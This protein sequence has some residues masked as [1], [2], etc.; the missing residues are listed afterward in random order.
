MIPRTS[1]PYHCKSTEESLQYRCVLY[2]N[3]VLGYIGGKFSIKISKYCVVASCCTLF[4]YIHLFFLCSHAN[5]VCTEE[6]TQ[7]VK[8]FMLYS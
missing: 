7:L 6:M 3:P 2:L 8:K 5:N 4:T 1:Y